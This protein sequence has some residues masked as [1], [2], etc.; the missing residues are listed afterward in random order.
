MAFEG[1]KAKGGPTITIDNTGK[2]EPGPVDTLLIALAACTTEDVLTILAKR[3]TPPTHL[4][5]EVE[6]K[7]AQATPA[8][9]CRL[10]CDGKWQRRS[11][12]WAVDLLGSRCLRT[13]PGPV[14][15][16]EDPW[17]EI[18]TGHHR[19]GLPHNKMPPFLMRGTPSA[20]PGPRVKSR[21]G[22]GYPQVGSLGSTL[23]PSHAS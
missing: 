16:Q 8:L 22:I 17:T 15:A 9:G 21:S 10:N 2:A 11:C 3:R 12:S 14:Y 23:G 4:H 18:A 5:I 1:R 7:R 13:R 20:P 6:G 19:T